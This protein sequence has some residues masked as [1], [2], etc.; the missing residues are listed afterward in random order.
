LISMTWYKKLQV[1][2]YIKKAN[3]KNNIRWH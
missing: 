2:G 1:V 3:K